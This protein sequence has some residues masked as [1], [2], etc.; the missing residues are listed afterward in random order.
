MKYYIVKETDVAK[1][2]NPNYKPGEV[3][4]V[5]VG[6]KDVVLSVGREPHEC[7]IRGFGYKRR[8]DAAKNWTF[9]HPGDWDA[10]IIEYD[11]DE[12][13]VREHVLNVAQ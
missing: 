8:Q 13:N 6:K 9:N 4:T 7:I 2:G 12:N 11:I 10:E 3:C 5:Y 1:C